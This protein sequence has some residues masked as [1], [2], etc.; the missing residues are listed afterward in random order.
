MIKGGIEWVFAPSKPNGKKLFEDWGYGIMDSEWLIAEYI[1]QGKEKYER[2]EFML[3]KLDNY[4]QQINIEIK[5]PR[6]DKIGTVTFTS[7]W[8]VYPNGVIE[9]VTGYGDK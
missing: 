8:M 9:L 5:L 4:G 2:G 3:H 7:G 1:R 6:K